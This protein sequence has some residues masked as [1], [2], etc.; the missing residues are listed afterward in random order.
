[1][2][3]FLDENI[4]K[5]AQTLIVERGFSF[6]DIRGTEYEGANDTILFRLAQEHHAVF[7]TTDRDYYHTIPLLAKEH[8]GLVVIALRQPNKQ[9]ILERLDWF[10][11]RF[12]S[13]DIQNKVFE[14]RDRT[15]IVRPNF[16]IEDK[17]KL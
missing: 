5:E 10:M 2:R 1:M 16:T 7:I 6:V 12:E 17:D 15:Y 8:C 13:C 9:R 11:D 4:P 14:L 3:Y